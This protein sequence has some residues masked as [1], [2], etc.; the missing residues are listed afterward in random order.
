MSLTHTVRFR[1]A[2]DDM[3]LRPPFSVPAL[4][5]PVVW[6]SRAMKIGPGGAVSYIMRP[7]VV[8]ETY[9]TYVGTTALR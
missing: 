8:R 5:L 3:V 9:S 7:T 2:L 1:E 4:F 6:S